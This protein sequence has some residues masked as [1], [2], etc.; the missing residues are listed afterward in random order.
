VRK[1]D[2]E[3]GAQIGVAYAEVFRVIRL[4]DN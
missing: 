1:W 3:N 4:V 2:A